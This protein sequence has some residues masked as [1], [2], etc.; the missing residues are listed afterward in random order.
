MDSVGSG[1]EGIEFNVKTITQIDA[2]TG[3]FAFMAAATALKSTEKGH[4]EMLRTSNN[5]RERFRN[6]AYAMQNARLE[7]GKTLTEWRFHG[8]EMLQFESAFSLLYNG[9]REA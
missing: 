6:I 1:K 8:S 9:A 2:H 4:Q 5:L 3:E 7:H